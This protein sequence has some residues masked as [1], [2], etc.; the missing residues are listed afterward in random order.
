MSE[1]NFLILHAKSSKLN[2]RLNGQQRTERMIRQVGKYRA[3][4]WLNVSWIWNWNAIQHSY[5]S[6]HCWSDWLQ[7]DVAAILAA[8]W[9]RNRCICTIIRHMVLLYMEHK[10][11]T[12]HSLKE[13][14]Y[15]TPDAPISAK[16]CEL[17]EWLI[18]MS[19]PFFSSFL[20]WSILFSTASGVWNWTG[21]K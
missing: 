6:P 20:L 13:L 1:M 21:I 5:L 8:R 18:K 10:P 4:T 3:Y 7:I 14:P 19:N 11:K 12:L 9:H 15:L 17:Q 16:D 2:R